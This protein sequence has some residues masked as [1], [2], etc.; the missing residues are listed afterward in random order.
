MKRVLK[1]VLGLFC[2]VLAVSGIKVLYKKVKG[3]SDYTS[4]DLGEWEDFEDEDT[5][6]ADEFEEVA[7]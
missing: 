6:I 7:R 2:G 1:I 4:Q 5:E 3:N